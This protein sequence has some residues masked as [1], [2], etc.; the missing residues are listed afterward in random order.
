MDG[1]EGDK[2]RWKG[3]TVKKYSK[4]SGRRT[5]IMQPKGKKRARN[6]VG[7]IDRDRM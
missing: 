1:E 7:P 6:E 5:I 2:V 4:K 3:I